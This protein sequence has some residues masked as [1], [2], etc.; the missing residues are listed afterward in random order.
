MSGAGWY[1]TVY[2]QAGEAGGTF[3]PSVRLSRD[4][5]AAGCAGDPVRAR[6][7]ARRRAR[8]KLRRYCA[9]NGLNRLG[10]LTYAGSGCHDPAQLRA[11]VGAFF[12]ELRDVRGRRPFPYVWVSEWHK[13]DH[14]LHVHFAVGEYLPQRVIREV[15]RRGFVSIKLIGDLPVG[16]GVVDEARRAA[17]YLSKYVAKQIDDD[18]RLLGSH[19]YDVAQGFQPARELLVGVSAAEVL[20]Q[21]SERFGAPPSRSWSSAE[22]PDWAG[23]PAVWAQWSGRRD[24]R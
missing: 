3:V 24:V 15:W 6:A 7:E 10:T 22:V 13:T 14:G 20:G 9:A 4:F 5:V 8:G 19:R 18:R 1:L 12:R 17:G 2:P 21:A 11:D 23:A 16:S